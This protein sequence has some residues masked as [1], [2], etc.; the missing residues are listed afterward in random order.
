[1][2]SNFRDTVSLSL[3]DRTSTLS[4]SQQLE[5]ELTKDRWDARNIPGLQYA[6]VIDLKCGHVLP[7]NL[8]IYPQS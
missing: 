4:P 6:L 3:T 2:I 1:M 7:R 8:H 5:M